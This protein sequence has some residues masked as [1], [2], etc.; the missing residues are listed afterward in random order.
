MGTTNSQILTP[1]VPRPRLFPLHLSPIENFMLADDQPGYPMTFVIHLQIAGQ[2]ERSAFQVALAESLQRHP[3]L[4]SLIKTAKGGM[5]CWTPIEDFQPAVHWA[6][7]TAPSNCPTDQPFDLSKQIGLRIWVRQGLDRATITLQFHHACTDGTGAYR[8]IGDCLAGYGMITMPGDRRPTFGEV[9]SSLLRTRRD[10]SMSLSACATRAQRGRLALGE[11]WKIL[12]RQPAPLA[13]ACTSDRRIQPADFPGFVCYSF[14]RTQH[15]CLRTAASKQGAMLNDLLIRDLFLTLD[16]WQGKHLSWFCRRRLRIMMPAELR[17]TEDYSMSA[18]NMVAYTFLA[19]TRGDVGRPTELLRTIREKT[20]LIK[21]ERSGTRFMDM[22]FAASQIRGLL[23]FVLRRK[24]CMASA[25]LSNVG[26][27]SRRFTAR[28]P[29]QGGR[30]AAGK[31]VLEEITGVPPLRPGTRATF[32]ISQ[33]DRRLTIS[34]RCDPNW[35][36]MEDS[37]S[38]LGLYV[39]QL[40]QSAQATAVLP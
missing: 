3:L 13:P 12:C 40:N 26:D 31:L 28:L 7:E 4:R 11:F 5:P 16:R 29:R 1:V 30:I 32:S 35:F 17:G 15:E 37:T 20:A 23:P 39:E 25:V 10:H 18:A 22:I 2:I 6:C 14:D 8:F 21:H 36:S 34:L 24:L 38:L 27:P 19:C 33:Y 9:D